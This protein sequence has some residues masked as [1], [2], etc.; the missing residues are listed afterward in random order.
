MIDAE[1]LLEATRKTNCRYI[2]MAN[3]RKINKNLTTL[4]LKLIKTVDK[5]N[6]YEDPE[7]AG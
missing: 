6:I 3:D 1:E 2:I 5:Y 4:G 7:V